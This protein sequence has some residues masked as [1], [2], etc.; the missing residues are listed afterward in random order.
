MPVRLSNFSE[1]KEEGI[2][3]RLQPVSIKWMPEP[4]LS[5]RYLFTSAMMSKA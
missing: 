1:D 5:L 3:L 2:E 4:V